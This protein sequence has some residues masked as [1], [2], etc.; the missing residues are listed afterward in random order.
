MKASA[1]YC[2]LAILAFAGCTFEVHQDRITLDPPVL[3][4]GTG[5]SK[6]INVR[7]LG[8]KSEDVEWYSSAESVASVSAGVVKGLASGTSLITARTV[9]K[10]L[11]A[12]CEVTVREQSEMVAGVKVEPSEVTLYLGDRLQLEATVLPTTAVNKNVNWTS[13]A[14]SVAT[15]GYTGYLTTWAEGTAVITATT[16]E[17][18]FTAECKVTVLP[19]YVHVESISIPNEIEV[20]VG[21]SVTLTPVIVPENAT[22]QRVVWHS[23]DESIVTVSDAGV[24][25]GISVGMM[26]IDVTTVEGNKRFKS[27]VYV[28]D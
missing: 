4:M 28:R 14:D 3:M 8:G 16:E 17:N 26:Y 1:K 27:L 24:V 11:M 23:Y 13:S 12:E 10:G 9:G 7:F 21:E 2:A 18:G 25:T 22:D 6:T 20:K 19:P 15:I 5:E